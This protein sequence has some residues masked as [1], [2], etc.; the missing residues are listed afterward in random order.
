MS[1]QTAQ[2]RP[3]S[4]KPGGCHAPCSEG[5]RFLERR[6]AFHLRYKRRTSL[7][8]PMRPGKRVK[9]SEANGAWRGTMALHGSAAEPGQVIW[10]MSGYHVR[11]NRWAPAR[12]YKGGPHVP[13][14]TRRR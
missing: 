8:L 7:D 13:R 9:T 10:E 6:G 11:R 14:G 3:A 12:S 5:R 1:P 2:S 4:D